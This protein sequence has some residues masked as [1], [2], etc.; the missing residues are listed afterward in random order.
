MALTTEERLV[1]GGV[2]VQ[3]AQSR[4]CERDARRP[5]DAVAFAA[6]VRHR[7]E[8]APPEPIM[9]GIAQA[10]SFV[11]KPQNATHAVIPPNDAVVCLAML[12]PMIGVK[13][14][15]RDRNSDPLRYQPAAWMGCEQHVTLVATPGRLNP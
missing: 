11:D 10:T 6:A 3:D 13:K 9:L 7:F 1:G 4:M 15:Y 8:H 12:W 14:R 5:I 2:E